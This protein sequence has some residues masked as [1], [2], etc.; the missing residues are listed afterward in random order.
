MQIHSLDKAQ[1]VNELQCGTSLNRAVEQ[2]RRADFALMLSMFSHDCR[3]TTLIEDIDT[4]ETDEALLRKRFDVPTAQKLQGLL[5]DYQTSAA[6][7]NQF[8][9]G[10]LASAKLQHYTAPEPLNYAPVD[11]QGLNEE[12]YQN[13]SGHTRRQLT[14]QGVLKPGVD[15]L[16]NQLSTAYRKDTLSIRL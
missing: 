10:G 1:L 2:G 16:Y 6:I 5:D 12:V 14:E 8:H 4:H 15:A 7:A 3:E 9:K 11:T 13:L